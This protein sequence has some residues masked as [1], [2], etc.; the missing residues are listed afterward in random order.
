[1]ARRRGPRRTADGVLLPGVVPD[2]LIIGAMK[3]GTTSLYRWLAEHRRVRPT[4]PKEIHFFDS[5]S[6][7]RD[8]GRNWY[9]AHFPPDADDRNWITGE[10]TPSYLFVPNVPE[11]VAKLA[12]DAKLIVLLRDPVDRARSHW[13][14]QRGRGREQAD[15]HEA[16]LRALRTDDRRNDTNPAGIRKDS[17]LRRGLYADQLERW[18]THFDRTRTLVL[19]S[20][21]LFGD[22]AETLGRVCGF[23]GI[24]PYRRLPSF[25]A[26]NVGAYGD[27]MPA[28]TRAMLREYFAPHNRRLYDLL[29]CDLG[30]D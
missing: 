17:Y 8:L 25:E 20:D 27:R 9:L 30:W 2:F 28:E 10:A 18:W 1:M 7:Y 14:H 4:N 3:C 26:Y 21:D 24:P 6:A 12:P 19:R 11:R 5:E 15:L 13:S 16:M 22:P 29:G 23:L